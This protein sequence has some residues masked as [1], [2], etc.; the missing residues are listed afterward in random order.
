MTVKEFATHGRWFN[1]DYVEI[2]LKNGTMKF[3][4]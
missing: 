1:G 4:D 3:G 2:A